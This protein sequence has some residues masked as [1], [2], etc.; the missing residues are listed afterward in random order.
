MNPAAW[1]LRISGRRLVP[2]LMIGFALVIIGAR[3]A[4]QVDA[5]GA[6]VLAQETARLRERMSID[7]GRMELRLGLDDRLFLRR[8]VSTLALHEGVQRAYLLDAQGVVR[9]SLSRLDI[10][11]PLPAVLAE[12]PQRAE[13]APLLAA[14][15]PSAI[16]VTTNPTHTALTAQVP[17]QAGHRLIVWQDLSRPLA[18]RRA[19]MLAEV[20]R[21][22]AVVLVAVAALALLLHLLWFQRARRLAQALAAMGNGDLTVR[23]GLQGRDELAHIGAEA[24]RMAAQLQQEHQRLQQMNQLVNRSPLVVIEWRNQPGWPVSY[25]SDSVAIWGYAPAQLLDGTLHYNDLFHPDDE[26]RV[27]AEIADY[28]AHGPDDYRQEYRIRRADGG[29]AWVDDRTSLQRDASGQVSSISGVLLDI[30]ARKQAEQAQREQAELLRMFYELPFLGMAISSPT[31]KRWMQVNDR[32]CEILG[33]PREE[34]LAMSWAEMTP[35]GDLERNVALFDELMA[36]QREG[37]RLAKRFVRKD[38]AFVYAEIDVRA[39]RDAAGRVQQLFATIQDVTERKAVDEA[40]RRS[41]AQLLEAQRIGR[42]GSWAYEIA[43]GVVTWSEQT[44]RIQELDPET[45]Q[46]SYDSFLSLIHPDDVDRVAQA[47]QRSVEQGSVYETRY[48]IRTRSG[49]IKHLRV[50]G[51]TQYQDGQPLRTVGMVVDETELVEAQIERD[52]LVSVMETTS[53]IVSMADPQGQVFYFNRAGY[54]V[55]GLPPG[56]LASDVIARVHPEWARKRVLD[57]AWPTVMREGRWLGETA[58]YNARGAE[59][60]MSQLIMAH[61]DAQGQVDYLWTILRDISERK[62][63]EAALNLERTQLNEAQAVARIGS[64]AF[65]MPGA[66]L[67]WSEQHFKVLGLDPT[68][69]VPSLDAFMSVVHPE[70][71]PWVLEHVHRD[72]ARQAPGVNR[73]EHR[74]VTDQGVRYVEERAGV[75]VDG[76]GQVCRIVGTTMDITERVLAEQALREAKDLLEQAEEVSLLGSWSGDAQTQRLVMSAQLF[77]NLGLEP[78]DQPPSDR[79]YLACIHPDDQPRVTEDMQRI[80]AG[81]E[82]RDM[83]F[84]T[85]PDQGPVRWLRRT[86][87]RIARDDQGLKPRYIGTLQDISDAVLAEERLRQTNQELEQRVAERT[88]QLRQA[89]QELEAFSYSVSHDLKAPLRGIDGY[90]QLLVEEYGSRLDEE[91]LRFVQRIRHGVQLMGDLIAD[92]LEYSRM[93]RRD[94]ARE[95]VDLVPLVMQV[96]DGY[97][98]DIQRQGVQVQTALEPGTLALDREGMAVVLR[99]LVGNAIKFSRDSQ[100]PRVEIGSRSEA[101]RR[102]LWVRD[103]GVGFDMKYHDRMFGI[104][105]RLHRAEEFPGTGV[106]LALV[107]KAVQRMGGR[108]WAESAPGAGATFYLEFPQ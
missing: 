76:Q 57:E 51:E 1:L 37:Y 40:L 33:Y 97:E 53:D 83:V 104:F 62:A 105:Q 63:A 66:V 81:G 46:P 108:V 95:P 21:E 58:V 82:A 15:Q 90:S 77:R 80:R 96:L 93:E 52:R 101:G 32:L 55:L 31:D 75:E 26:P 69:T 71:R 38:G 12:L 64:W 99:N 25:V 36:G 17:L 92:L 50:R 49:R 34:L 84:R 8:L 7:Q 91:G 94:M 100:P 44:Y 20:A 73:F 19:L 35:P 79:A 13:L 28:F 22:A 6:E 23:S 65:Q 5:I 24:D 61:H 88:A 45:F 41:Q 11:R 14:A 70:D 86:A 43:S 60:P 106:G 87:R 68:R 29:W 98:A 67:S 59:V 78:A 27:N 3:Y 48:R 54:D 4:H 74:I 56:P 30:T 103:N 9:A 39:V 42:M 18:Q 2:L 10:A 107:A 47:Y 102:M 16:E 72:L 89:N 85:H